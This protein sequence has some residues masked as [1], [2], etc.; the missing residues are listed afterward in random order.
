MCIQATDNHLGELLYVSE[1]M[2]I[3]NPVISFLTT[4]ERILLCLV[5]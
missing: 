3:I 4:F 5:Q 1:Y 2:V